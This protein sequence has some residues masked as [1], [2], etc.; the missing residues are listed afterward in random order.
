[1][2]SSACKKMT[3]KDKV[4]DI[5]ELGVSIGFLGQSLWLLNKVKEKK[6]EKK[7]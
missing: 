3:V 5:A 4:E 2:L 1:M 6:K 7:K